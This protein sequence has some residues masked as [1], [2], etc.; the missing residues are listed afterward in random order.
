MRPGADSRAGVGILGDIRATGVQ[1]L[2]LVLE[3]KPL[4][5]ER[6]LAWADSDQVCNDVPEGNAL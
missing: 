1:R 2:M 6:C 3:R 4:K 5:S